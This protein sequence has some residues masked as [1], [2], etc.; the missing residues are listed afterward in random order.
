MGRLRLLLAGLALLLGAGLALAG[1]W[2]WSRH[3]DDPVAVRPPGLLDVRDSL[4]PG[5]TL[6]DLL[7]R[8]RMGA[9]DL[10]GLLERAGLDARRLRAGLI[11]DFL[12][13]RG[14]SIP[15][16]VSF[17]ARDEERVAIR[18]VAD[19]WIPERH[20]VAW[21]TEVV[22]FEGP[23]ENSLYE[24]LDAAIPDAM[25]D[26]GER[27]R[28]AWDLADVYAW[29]VDFNRDIQEGD[30]FAVLI[31]RRISAE[32]EVRSGRVLAADLLLTGRHLDAFRFEGEPGSAGYF[33]GAGKSL[34]RAFLRAPVEFRRIS[35]AFSRSRYHP[36]LGIFRKH[37]GTDYAAASG[38]PVLASGDG[39]VLRAGPAGG[40]GNLIELR[41]RNGI[42]TRYGHLRGFARGIHAGARV[43]QGEVIGFVG[44]TGLASGPHLH[45]EFRV[46]GVARDSRRV[47]LG[48]GEPIRPA[49]AVRFGR[50]RDRLADLLGSAGVRRPAAAVS[51]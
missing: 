11:V 43:R 29:S 37:E 22:R 40:Y 6:G 46:G 24:A 41:H 32:G 27:V 28:L 48:S 45:Y 50:E 39:T 44:A 35:S 30:R 13:R 12:H 16:Q 9:I 47:L 2:P 31:E 51:E 14:D 10:A 20:P 5:E 38:T 36:V 33:D 19:A 7:G 1:R 8:H 17:R 26:A 18:R 21:R 15:S 4:R 3:S 34:R 25:L 49:L 42:T 23:I